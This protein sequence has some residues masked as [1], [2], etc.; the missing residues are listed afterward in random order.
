M[1]DI[2]DRILMASKG[3]SDKSIKKEKQWSLSSAY[4]LALFLLVRC[5]IDHVNKAESM[6][7]YY[8][9]TLEC[10]NLIF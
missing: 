10:Q 2:I 7:V 6:V 1:W 5:L 8:E 4:N 3:V 9:E